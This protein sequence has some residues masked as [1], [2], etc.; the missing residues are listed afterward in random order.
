M[1]NTEKLGSGEEN[2]S[3][4]MAELSNE[5][6]FEEHMKKRTNAERAARFVE[7]ANKEDNVENALE[8]MSPDDA[9]N[10][11]QHLNSHLRN[12]KVSK[13]SEIYGNGVNRMVVSSPIEGGEKELIAPDPELQRELFDEY[14]EAIKTIDDKDKKAA[15]AYYALNNLHLF[16]DGNGRTSRAVYYLIKNGNLSDVNKMIEHNNSYLKYVERGDGDDGSGRKDF[17]SE[18]NLVS[19][20]RMDNVANLFLQEQMEK[21]GT[22]SEDFKNKKIAVYSVVSVENL[23][24]MMMPNKVR[25][26][27]SEDES[28]LIDYA[29]SDGVWSGSTS[30]ISGLAVATIFQKKG[31]SKQVIDTCQKEDNDVLIRVNFDDEDSPAKVEEIKNLFSEWTPNDYRKLIETYRDVKRR[32]NETIIEFF[33]KDTK[34]DDGKSVADWTMGK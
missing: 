15:L 31:L 9:L 33:T 27:L 26:S 23:S 8:K 12:E 3:S 2:V 7:L 4:N 16:S 24:H 30:T 11:L 13:K 10:F 34:F 5:P 19:V 20:E 29:I 17:S 25:G 6:S 28:K 18:N 21:D 22:L 14:F 32:Q 1:N